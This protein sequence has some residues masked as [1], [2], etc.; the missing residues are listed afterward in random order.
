MRCRVPSLRAV[1]AAELYDE[2]LPRRGGKVREFEV[3]QSDVDYGTQSSSGVLK[4]VA[5][6][7]RSGGAERREVKWGPTS[8]KPSEIA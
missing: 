7:M 3:L 4:V 2:V 5:I 1:P 8:P 6:E